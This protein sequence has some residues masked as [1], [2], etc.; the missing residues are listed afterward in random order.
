MSGICKKFLKKEPKNL[1]SS[2]NNVY[3]I[4]NGKIGGECSAHVAKEKAYKFLIRTGWMTFLQK[5]YLDE[6]TTWKKELTDNRVKIC[7]GFVWISNKF[8]DQHKS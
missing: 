6:S 2:P 5:A 7:K 3:Y 4:R 8:F 1:C